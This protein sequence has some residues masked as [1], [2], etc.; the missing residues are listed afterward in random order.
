LPCHCHWPVNRHR[1]W[2]RTVHIGKISIQN[3]IIKRINNIFKISAP[4]FVIGNHP[5]FFV[6]IF[7]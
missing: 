4:R 7:K 2:L 3:L 1:K 5:N 6:G